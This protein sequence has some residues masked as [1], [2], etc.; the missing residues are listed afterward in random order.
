VSL[1][2]LLN[3]DSIGATLHVDGAKSN[4]ATMQ[5]CNAYTVATQQLFSRHRF[6]AHLLFK[7]SAKF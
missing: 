6:A 7:S 2:I 5:Q 4:R 1:S 3:Y